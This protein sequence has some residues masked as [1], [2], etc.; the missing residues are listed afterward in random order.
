[1]HINTKNIALSGMLMAISVICIVLGSFVQ[2]NTLVFLLLAAF[3]SGAVI[4]DMGLG[5]GAMFIAG[6][7]VLG[8][9]LGPNKMY[10]LTYLG[11]AIYIFLSE[12][13]Y[14]CQ[15]AIMTKGVNLSKTVWNCIIWTYKF[16]VFNIIYL[17]CLLMMPEVILSEEIL[18]K[19]G[20]V[21]AIAAV[22]GQVVWIILDMVYNTFIMKFWMQFRKRLK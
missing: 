6:T 4:F 5:A 13:A 18:K 14:R 15:N 11:F 19:G 20:F 1:M 8:F 3:L 7:F 2:F 10:A 17:I 12:A 9:F 22:A 21:I 16:F